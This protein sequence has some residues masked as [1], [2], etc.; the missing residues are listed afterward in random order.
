M[1]KSKVR[2]GRFQQD[3]SGNSK[4]QQHFKDSADVNNIVAHFLSTGVDPHEDRKLK[5]QFGYASSL[6]FSEAMR[7]I[8]EIN[9]AFAELPSDERMTFGNDPS[10]WIGHLTTP[11]PEADEIEPQTASQDVSEAPP[12]D[13]APD[14]DTAAEST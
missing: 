5:Q 9:T 2:P 8:A 14:P 7:N 12:S 3:F 13:P 1:T 4:T 6:D 11:P 10:R